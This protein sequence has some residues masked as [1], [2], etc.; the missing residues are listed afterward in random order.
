VGGEARGV[1]ERQTFRQRHGQRPVENVARRG[2]IDRRNT[3]CGHHGAGIGIFHERAARTA[4]DDHVLHPLVQQRLRCGCRIRPVQYGTSRKQGALRLVGRKE[5]DVFQVL[6]VDLRRRRRIE[7]HPHAQF[8]GGLYRV[9]H[10]FE[11]YFELDQQI[12][13]LRQFGPDVIDILSG[14]PRI[15]TGSHDDAV[16]GRIIDRDERHTRRG[17]RIADD[18]RSIHLF[19]GVA[20]HQL[21]SEKVGPDTRHEKGVAAQPR[22]GD[23]LIGAFAA[24][25]DPE[26]AAENGLAG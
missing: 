20:G 5:V 2:R 8:G 4:G 3:A 21:I 14:K 25:N 17:L 12:A 23:G 15:R 18:M 24:G 22:D 10:G 6:F 1:Q 16:F 7:N 11:R 26:F 19:R 9:F 13:G